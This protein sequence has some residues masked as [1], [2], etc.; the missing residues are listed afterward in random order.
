MQWIHLTGEAQLNQLISQ[1]ASRPQVI[2]KHSTRCSVSSV[3]LQRLQKAQAP[4]G[5]DFNFLDLLAYR[6]LSN[7]IAEKF[8]VRHESPQVLIIKNGTCVY[9]ESHLNI[10]MNDIAEHALAA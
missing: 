7:T 3:A 2:F 6:S 8:G 5:V 9:D 10:S 4:E 1:S